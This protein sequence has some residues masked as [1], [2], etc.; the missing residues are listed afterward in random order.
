MLPTEDQAAFGLGSPAKHV[1]QS[2]YCSQLE[3]ELEERDAMDWLMDD[4]MMRQLGR[5]DHGEK[6]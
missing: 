6:K 3:N 2:W 1:N 4:E 5:G